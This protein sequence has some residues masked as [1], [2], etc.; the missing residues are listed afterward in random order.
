MGFN[1]DY[2]DDDYEFSCP[3]CGSDKVVVSE[4]NG[5]YYIS[6]CMKCGYKRES[7]L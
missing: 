1:A 7:K 4:E 6:S 2:N 3:N 5:Y